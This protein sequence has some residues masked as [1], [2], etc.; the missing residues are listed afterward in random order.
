LTDP[1]EEE[2]NGRREERVERK[3][4]QSGGERREE[5][6]GKSARVQALARTEKGRKEGRK[7]L[8]AFLNCLPRVIIGLPLP[9]LE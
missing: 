8:F 9:S 7:D 5:G 3:R 4:E 6:C 1:D 2:G